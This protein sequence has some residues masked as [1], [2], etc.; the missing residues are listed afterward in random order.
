MKNEPQVFHHRLARQILIWVYGGCPSDSHPSPNHSPAFCYHVHRLIQGGY[1]RGATQDRPGLNG[2]TV[3]HHPCIE[4]L[5]SQGREAAEIL[6]DDTLLPEVEAR[7][8]S[9]GGKDL[10]FHRWLALFRVREAERHAAA[11]CE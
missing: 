4:G 8:E 3:F 11:K 6:F 2:T 5:T 1:L 7:A 9:S 10:P